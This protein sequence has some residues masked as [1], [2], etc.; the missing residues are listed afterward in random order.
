VR[1]DIETSGLS[2][3]QWMPHATGLVAFGGEPAAVPEN[4]ITAV[5][6][7]L[8]EINEAGEVPDLIAALVYT[9]AS[10]ATVAARNRPGMSP[11][12]ILAAIHNAAAQT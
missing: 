4:L 9:A 3:F 11:E 7:R 8:D 5:R 1:V 6:R 12:D 10:L 2:V